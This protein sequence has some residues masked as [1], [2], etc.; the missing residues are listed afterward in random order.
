MKEHVKLVDELGCDTILCSAIGT[1]QNGL[2][3]KHSF[4]IVYIIVCR[5]LGMAARLNPVT[6]EP[7]Y[8]EA[9]AEGGA[10]FVPLKA[11]DE[12]VARYAVSIDNAS[13][14]RLKYGEHIT[15]GKLRDGRYETL[16]YPED[17][18]EDH[19]NIEV[20]AG[21]YRILSCFRQIDGTVSVYAYYYNVPEVMQERS[22]KSL[23]CFP[24]G[25]KPRIRRCR[26][27]AGNGTRSACMYARTGSI[28]PDFI[29][30]PR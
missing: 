29:R 28:L 18:L 22:I 20:E 17:L 11:E 6:R 10:S 4:A 13:D 23:Y 3:G 1:L 2:C 21:S 14:R 5:A 9:L 15:V 19:W 27:Y 25:K 7:E 8:N 24:P 16:S 12:P 30:Y 26:E